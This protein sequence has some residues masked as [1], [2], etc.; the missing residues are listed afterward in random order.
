MLTYLGVKNLT[1]I[2]KASLEFT[3]G[4]NVITGETGA[5]KSVLVGALKFLTGERFNR[6]VLRDPEKKLAVEGIFSA[7]G[8][9]DNELREQYEIEDELIFSREADEAGRSKVF[10]NGRAAP[11]TKLKEISEYLI[12][13]HGQHENQFLFD[14]AKHLGF[15]DFF[16]EQELKENYASSYDAY[17]EKASELAS[18]KKRAEDAAR[19][20]EMYEFQFEEISAFNINLEKDER[21]DE[22]IEFLSNIE[23][24]REATA[25]C[26][27][28]LK[29]GEISAADLVNRAERSLSGVFN[30]APELIKAAE[31]LSAAASSIDDA[32]SYIESVFEKQ[33]EASPNELNAL[34]DRKY[35]LQN[36]LKKY[37]SELREVLAYKDNLA[38]SLESAAS[39]EERISAA[40]KEL[41]NFKKNAIAAASKLNDGRKKAAS[42]ISEKVCLIL[43]EL[44]LPASRFFV[45]FTNAENLDRAGGISV[46]FYISTNA[47]FEPGPLSS[48][49][50]GGEIS[51][52]ML[53]LKEVFAE[54]DS[55]DTLLFDEIDTGI[56]GRAAKSVAEK[57]KKLSKTKQIIVITHLP[58]VAAQGDVHFHISKSDA[59]GISR[60]DILKLEDKMREN[61]IA[62]MIAGE[63]TE[64]AVLQAKELLKGTVG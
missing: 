48:V 43:K 57:L 4:L 22:R 63:A 6:A 59:A 39:G 28:F 26:L 21:I 27:D 23:K 20:K 10:I 9:I 49:A 46:E 1:V 18:L 17:R 15:L 50:S 36:L 58:V 60:T 42:D 3:A 11:I 44:E 31:N 45:K 25:Q 52:V 2:E 54:A 56:S 8:S 24:I 12:D 41:T 30:L 7:A 38:K 62:T 33:D 37:G 61:V 35:G 51:R 40:E 29:S 14:P 64:Q 32:V 13:I 19:L 47:G 55:I 16:V 34:I 5:G 53:A